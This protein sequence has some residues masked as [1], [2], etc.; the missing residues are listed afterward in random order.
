MS[1]ASAVRPLVLA[2]VFACAPGLSACSDDGSADAEDDTT[3]TETSTEEDTTE[4][5][6]PLCAD[7]PGFGDVHFVGR[8]GADSTTDDPI[9]QAL[10]IHGQ[11]EGVILASMCPCGS[12]CSMG[13]PFDPFEFSAFDEVELP[14]CGTVEYAKRADIEA[15]AWVVFRNADE[16]SAGQLISAGGTDPSTVPASLGGFAIESLGATECD[17]FTLLDLRF[18][19]DG[20]SVEL[21]P[22]ESGELDTPIGAVTVS[23]RGAWIDELGVARHSW[24]MRPVE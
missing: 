10:S 22:G 3:D 17:G 13:G 11:A 12:D 9:V 16:G 4:T 7:G 1:T 23:N 6:D 24:V 18:S 5:G 15:G 19:W 8:F 2:C 14:G 20:A 21:G